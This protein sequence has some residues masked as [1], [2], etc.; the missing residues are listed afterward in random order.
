MI[1]SFH[2]SFFWETSYTAPMHNN[3]FYLEYSTKRC[4]ILLNRHD[5]IMT[6]PQY[7]RLWPFGPQPHRD[8]NVWMNFKNSK[9]TS[10]WRHLHCAGCVVFDTLFT[11]RKSGYNV[12]LLFRLKWTHKSVSLWL[13]DLHFC[14]S[15]VKRGL[16]LKDSSP[17]VVQNTDQ[18]NL[19]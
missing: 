13:W 12:G 6:W 19:T 5:V 10:V 11:S 1:T 16:P 14:L 8:N 17:S 7:P 4:F 9:L 18:Q 2:I 15:K 3:R